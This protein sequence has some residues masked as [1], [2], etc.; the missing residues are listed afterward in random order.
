MKTAVMPH[1]LPWIGT[2]GLDGHFGGWPCSPKPPPNPALPAG[3]SP[4]AAGTAAQMSFMSEGLALVGAPCLKCCLLFPLCILGWGALFLGCL[5][6]FTLVNS[7]WLPKA[8]QMLIGFNCFG[9]SWFYW[10]TDILWVNFMYKYVGS[11]RDGELTVKPGKSL[12]W[13]PQHNFY[14]LF[15]I[16]L[17][18]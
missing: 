3:F 4:E 1:S 7:S 17:L 10:K 15:K 11:Q 5:R 12:G 16:V 2:G 13:E 9:N 6:I 14:M 8:S 18:K